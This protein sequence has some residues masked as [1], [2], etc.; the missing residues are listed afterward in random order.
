M[1]EEY[2]I[3]PYTFDSID[4]HYR[5]RYRV[6]R[7]RHFLGIIP[8]WETVDYVSNRD[9]G[10]DAIRLMISRGGLSRREWNEKERRMRDIDHYASVSYYDKSG[11]RINKSGLEQ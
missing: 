5:R 11:K 4:E 2:R 1:Y 3:E 8:Y 7:L 9:E 6:Q 10:E